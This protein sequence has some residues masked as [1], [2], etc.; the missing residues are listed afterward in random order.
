MAGGGV[1]S[2]AA[3]SR[4]PKPLVPVLGGRSWSTSCCTCVA[5]RARRDRDRSVHGASIRN[6][7]GDGSEQGV[8]LTILREDRRWVRG[9][10]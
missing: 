4:Q 5:T 8:A 1:A 7:F 6:Y 3:T 2:P 9:A 10:P